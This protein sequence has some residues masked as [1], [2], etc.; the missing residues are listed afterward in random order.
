MKM[1]II[2]LFSIGLRILARTSFHSCPVLSNSARGAVSELKTVVASSISGA[3][4][5]MVCRWDMKKIKIKIQGVKK[6]IIKY[7]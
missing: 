3:M 4:M 6:E 1:I 2:V 5:F 7:V